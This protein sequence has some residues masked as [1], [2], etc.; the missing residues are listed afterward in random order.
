MERWESLL[1]E[2]STE[3]QLRE[4][5][6]ELLHAID[7]RLLENERPLSTTFEFIVERTKTLLRSD[8]VGILLRRGRFLESAYTTYQ[9]ELGQRVEISN[10][11]AGECIAANKT[12]SIPD[13]SEAGDSRKYV[14]IA[15]Y[16]GPPMISLLAAP[17]KVHDIM[18]G[19]LC[20]ESTR[21]NA[22]S[23]VH[24]NILTAVAAQVAIA[25]QRAQLFNR[26]ELFAEVDQL[27]FDEDTDSQ[28]AIQRALQRV[29]D[30]LQELE[31]VEITSA[32]IVFRAA[33]DLEVMHSTNQA[34]VGLI[35]PLEDSIAGRAVREGRTVIIGDVSQE[36]EFRRVSR[37]SIQSEIAIPISVGGTV[38]GLLNV[39]SNQLDA[40]SG[41]SQVILESFADKVRVLL[42]FAK[43]RAELTETFEVRNVDNL[44]V[45]VG[46]QTTHMIHQLNNS[47][48][49]MR[50][51]LLELEQYLQDD[52]EIP[53]DVLREG[54]TALLG[55]AERTLE[56]PEELSR[57]LRQQGN[58]VDVNRAV[59]AAVEK[60]TVP[61]T[62][63]V[64]KELEPRIPNLSL[65]CFD[66]VIQNLLQNAL[67]SMPG[68]GTLTVYT[69]AVF[70]S[71]LPAG[72][73][74][75]AVKDTGTGIPEDILARIFELNFT[76]KRTKG[77]GLGLWW[78]RNFVRRA[79]G[80]IKVSS[81]VDHGSTFTIR[82]PCDRPALPR[83][84]HGPIQPEA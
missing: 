10:S 4:D 76:T 77:S 72:Y 84:A 13:I 25:L 48:G 61:S 74:Q 23:E 36:P 16:T 2:L 37:A 70:H 58:V 53:G 79:G 15:D 63:I 62:V 82:I 30:A 22:F 5:E 47:V 8:H 68:G 31:H 55:L 44:L 43:L 49:A 6:L 7:L 3:F 35:L 14:P 12:I 64:E 45:A 27:I 1:E 42:A 33:R 80:E 29:M 56:M 52:G 32:D 83:G 41:F 39:E 40:F 73:V 67:D 75:I 11:L 57:L 18:V 46:D 21:A 28:L 69:S 20:A 9:S 51:R 54:I 24:T 26:D 81:K 19:A 38:I 60:L 78:L 65:Y 66:I 17:I 34:D 50:F 59:E 71:D